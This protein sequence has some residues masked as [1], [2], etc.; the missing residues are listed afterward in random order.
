MSQLVRPLRVAL[1][2]SAL[3][4]GNAGVARLIT[5]L[6]AAVEARD[7]VQLLRI[8]S[9]AAPA[10]GTIGRRALALRLDLA[11]HL[12][13]ARREAAHI[14]ADVLHTPLPRGPLRPGQPPTVVTIHDLAVVRYPET[15]SGW[16]RRY[17]T[18]T[19]RRMLNAADAIVAVSQDTAADIAA[20]A[21]STQT[22]ITVITN[23]VESSWSVPID[24]RPTVD[25]PYVLAVGTAEP[26]KNL[27]RLVE[28]MQLRRDAGAPERLVLVGAD[29]WGK[30]ALP[31]RP[32][33]IRLGRVDDHELRLL[34]QHAMALA[35]PSLHEG[36]GLPVLE[37]FAAGLP[38]VAAARGALPETADGAAVLVN[39]LDARE[40]AAGI[41]QAISRCDELAAAGRIR[42][43]AA[44]WERVAEQY[45]EVYRSV[46][47]VL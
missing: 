45:A 15:L 4:L 47:S 22:R 41:D 38:V 37:A 36:S 28:A 27:P 42:A 23:G 20:F 3:R 2:V 19:L 31:D 13:G 29:G 21:P 11:W 10:P 26:R 14:G 32:W 6:A 5:R 39:P 8:G 18:R 17:T 43:E 35:I 34:Y 44:T 7:D 40:I 25:G 33:L 1:D 46:V 30:A 12:R 24:G 16:N 9:G